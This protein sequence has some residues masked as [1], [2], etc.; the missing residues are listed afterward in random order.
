M[1]SFAENAAHGSELSPDTQLLDEG[2]TGSGSGA[3]LFDFF[4]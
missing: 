1:M 4:G 3:I 2:F